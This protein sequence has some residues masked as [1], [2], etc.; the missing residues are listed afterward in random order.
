MKSKVQSPKSK[1]V[2]ANGQSP[3]LPWLAGSRLLRLAVALIVFGLWT[4]D[5]GLWTCEAQTI[6]F[7]NAAPSVYENGT[8]VAVIVTR[9]PA[10]GV[11]TVDYVTVDNTAVAGADYQITTGTLTFNDGDSFQI[12]TIPIINDNLPEGTETFFVVLSNP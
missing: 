1:V 11:A 5:F 6:Q 10:S 2:S 12:I 8:N 9:T 4:L 3:A 7:L